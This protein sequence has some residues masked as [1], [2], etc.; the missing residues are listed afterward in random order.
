MVEPGNNVTASVSHSFIG[1]GIYNTDDVM[2]RLVKDAKVELYVNDL[3]KGDLRFDNIYNKFVSDIEIKPDDDIMIRANSAKYGEASGHTHIPAIVPGAT[4]TYTVT[5]ETDYDIT[6]VDWDGNVSHPKATIFNYAITFKDPADLENYYFLMSESLYFEC[7]DPIIGENDSPLDAVY[8][9][10]SRYFMFSDKSISG[11][12]YTLTCSFKISSYYFDNRIN[13]VC[14]YSISK[15]YYLYLLS[16]YKK[17]EGLNGT[18]EEFGLAE[19]KFI[20]SNVNPG[21]GIVAAQ[22]PVVDIAHDVRDY[23][24]ND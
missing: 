6:L 21:V 15:D 8:S 2:E 3:Y 16:L 5:S 7:D 13:K 1:T 20:Y 11:K 14:L 19:P 10:N 22:T 24:E 4:W 12:E 17:Y 23:F 9:D 18:L